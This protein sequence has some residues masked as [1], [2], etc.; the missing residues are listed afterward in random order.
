MPGFTAINA[1]SGEAQSPATSNAPSSNDAKSG[2]QKSKRRQPARKTAATS[3]DLSEDMSPINTENITRKRISG[4]GRKRK[5]PSNDSTQPKRQKNGRVQSNMSTT[6]PGVNA[7][8]ASDEYPIIT[9]D[10]PS[11]SST[12][13]GGLSATSKAKLD[14]FRY[15]AKQAK[16]GDATRPDWSGTLPVYTSQTPTSIVSSCIAIRDALALLCRQ[17]RGDRLSQHRSCVYASRL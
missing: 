2:Q 1:H 7:T 9:A 15:N 16:T 8:T 12:D 13:L 4:E 14:G 17:A 10:E 5:V 11:S 3:N 6:K